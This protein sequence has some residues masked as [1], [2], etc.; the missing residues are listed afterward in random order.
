MPLPPLES[1]PAS[2]VSLDDY[3][4]L[5]RDRVEDSIWAYL[6]GAA[7]DEVTLRENRAGFER[8]Q[9]L[10][11]IFRVLSQASTGLTLFGRHYAHPVFI[12][13]TAFHGM[14][15]PGGEVVTMLGASAMDA[16]MTV[17]TQAGMAIEDIARG[18][19][20]PPWFQLYIQPDRA[21]TAELVKRVE[22]A[23]CAALVI[24]AD[25]PLHGLR[26]REQRA[27]FRVPPGLE[28]VN[29][30]GME[31]VP[32]AD[33][34]FGSHLLAK[35]PT[36]EDLAWLRSL[37]KLPLVLKGV[38]DPADALQAEARGVDGIIVSNHGGRTLD[39][40]PA[41]I[42]V[43]PSVAAAIG[44]R[45]P[46]LLDGGIRRGTDVLK[47]LALGASAVMVGR[48]ILHGL[49]AA[50]ATGVAHVLKILRTELEIA[51]A[52]TGRATLDELDPSVIFAK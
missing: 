45:L 5:A 11:R 37:T 10:P 47:A 4:V 18:A 24:T 43:L 2:I 7:A 29:L 8:I 17:S 15:Y 36:W 42:E 44:D 52:L 49:A 50:G 48:P 39:T 31:P 28:P 32:P 19:A 46:I 26:N 20:V 33:R 6:S 9:L 12:A 16:C 21:F 40:V 13:P 1:I 14:F 34:I 38:L 22:A 27:A 35:A 3:E 51:M 23:G 25:A 41:A 30:R